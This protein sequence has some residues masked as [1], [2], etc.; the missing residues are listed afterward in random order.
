MNVIERANT[1]YT[2]NS[3]FNNICVRCCEQNPFIELAS[4]IFASLEQKKKECTTHK[5]AAK[6]LLETTTTRL[7]L[8]FQQLLQIG[9][10]V[11]CLALSHADNDRC[12]QSEDTTCFRLDSEGKLCTVLDGFEDS[13]RLEWDWP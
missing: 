1:S 13:G 4:E 11:L 2:E 5:L 9:K 7:V 8:G 3:L 10:V 12:D 6:L